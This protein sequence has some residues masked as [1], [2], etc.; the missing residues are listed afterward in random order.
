MYAFF[1]INIPLF[2]VLTFQLAR[3]STRRSTHLEEVLKPHSQNTS[4]RYCG[5]FACY[6]TFLQLAFLKYYLPNICFLDSIRFSQHF[7]DILKP[8]FCVVVNLQLIIFE[9]VYPIIM[10]PNPFLSVHSF[11]FFSFYL[12]YDNVN[13][14]LFMFRFHFRNTCSG[15]LL[16]LQMIKPIVL[17]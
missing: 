14:F 17:F 11:A 10:F 3:I 8:K 15:V 5:V 9:D 1:S 12:N 4:T 6:F 2:C 16:L 7:Y 13:L